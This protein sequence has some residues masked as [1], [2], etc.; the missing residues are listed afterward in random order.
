MTFIMEADWRRFE[1][2]WSIT[3]SVINGR[4]ASQ[5]WDSYRLRLSCRNNMLDY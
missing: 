4:A 1:T 2:L 3:K 5:G